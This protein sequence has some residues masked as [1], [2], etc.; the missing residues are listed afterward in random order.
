MHTTWTEKS[1]RTFEAGVGALFEQGKINCPLHLSGGNERPLIS[2]FKE[3]REQ[4]WVFS[5]HR[6]HYHYLLKGGNEQALL[7]ELEGKPTGCCKG[8]GRSMHIY[9]KKLN[10]YTS[11]IVAGCCSIAVGVAMG[12]KQEFGQDQNS[13]RPHVWVFLGD[14]AEDSGH[15][16]E[17]VRLSNARELPITFVIEDNDFSIDSPKSLR[18]HLYEPIMDHRIVRFKYKRMYPHVGIGKWVDFDGENTSTTKS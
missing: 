16:V 7:D 12:I 13:G 10:F 11:A 3:I 8:A 18:W 1:L 5:T 4:D 14:G 17:A 6:N 15:F 2:I 9:D